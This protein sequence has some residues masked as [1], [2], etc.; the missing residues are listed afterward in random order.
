MGMVAC[1]T[2]F[3]L[4]QFQGE[5]L[6]A[7]ALLLEAFSCAALP[8]TYLL[9]FGFTVSRG[10]HLLGACT[11]PL[12]PARAPA[13]MMA[14]S[15]QE[16]LAASWLWGQMPDLPHN[17]PTSLHQHPAPCPQ[18]EMRALQRLNSIFFMT[19]YLGFLSTWIMDVITM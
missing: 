12:S 8:L 19:G 13:V 10:S 18:D 16:A 5:R 17:I 1:F 7:A 9:Q 3:N 4:P 6:A 14:Q 2:F 15:R 11:G